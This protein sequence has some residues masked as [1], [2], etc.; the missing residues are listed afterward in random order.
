MAMT[1]VRNVACRWRWLLPAILLL[2]CDSGSPIRDSGVLGD[3]LPPGRGGS[4]GD[5]PA[6]DGKGGSDGAASEGGGPIDLASGP[7]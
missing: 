6:G 5:A 2:G 1:L 4:T 3:A 7:V